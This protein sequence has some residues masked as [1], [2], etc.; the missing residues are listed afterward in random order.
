MNTHKH[1]CIFLNTIILY[2]NNADIEQVC[3]PYATTPDSEK[4]E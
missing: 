2:K 4:L 3:V 1:T